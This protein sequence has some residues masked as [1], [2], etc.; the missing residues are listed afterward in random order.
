M[1][2]S[3]ACAVQVNSSRV[4]SASSK[5]GEQRGPW[6]KSQPEGKRRSVSQLTGMEEREFSLLVPSLLYADAQWIG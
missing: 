3:R 5:A 6:C 4:V 2:V 1:Q